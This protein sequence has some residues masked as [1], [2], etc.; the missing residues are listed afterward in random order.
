[1]E[2]RELNRIPVDLADVKVLPDLGYFGGG[3][4]ICSAPDA[5]CGF[6]LCCVSSAHIDLAH[7]MT[8]ETV[9]MP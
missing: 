1:M 6:V 3:D 4:V 7:R 2:G 5:F 8:L 9:L